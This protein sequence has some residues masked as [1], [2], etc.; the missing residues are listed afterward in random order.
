MKLNRTVTVL[1]GDTR[2]IYAAERLYELGHSVYVYGFDDTSRPVRLPKAETLEKALQSDIIVLPLPV[3]KNNKTLNAS[4]SR[5]EI[6]LKDIFDNMPEGRLVLFGMGNDIFIRELTSTGARYHDYFSREEL[7]IKNALL[8]AEGITGIIL[9]KLPVTVYKLN[10]AITGYGR[11]GFFT[12]KLLHAM[13]AD[14]TVYARNSVQRAK[15]ETAGMKASKLTEL[16]DGIQTADCV[17]NTV[18]S[19]LITADIITL[20]KPECLFIETA[21][22]PYGIDFDACNTHGRTLVKAFSLPGKTSP[23]TAGIIIADTVNDI[24]K[25][26]IE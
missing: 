19:K 20:S 7:I 3:T 2:Q 9:D 15:A 22:S 6:L 13:G 10:A 5:R 18:P 1:G 8:T 4:F 25:E 26:V 24:I 21:S 12:A 23:K 11:V 17:I 16:P 14:V